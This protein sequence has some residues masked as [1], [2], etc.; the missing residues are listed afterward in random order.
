MLDKLMK[1]GSYRVDYFSPHACGTD[2]AYGFYVRGDV[3]DN[4]A[5]SISAK[6]HLYAGMLVIEETLGMKNLV[7]VYV[8]V[9]RAENIRRPAYQAMKADIRKGYFTRI[10]VMCPEDLLSDLRCS[11]DL[12]ELENEVGNLTIITYN[13]ESGQLET[14]EVETEK[15]P[16]GLCASAVLW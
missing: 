13:E 11:A 2:A 15:K 10:F 4:S 12:M 5:Y 16:E 6:R 9:D 3:S 14:V 1:N 8:D 7:G